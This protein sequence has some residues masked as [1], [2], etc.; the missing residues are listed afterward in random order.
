MRLGSSLTSIFTLCQEAKM[1][2]MVKETKKHGTIHRREGRFL[3]VHLDGTPMGDCQL[4]NVD[5]VMIYYENEKS[6]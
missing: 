3:Y 1:R 6:A 4:L 5:E 2:C